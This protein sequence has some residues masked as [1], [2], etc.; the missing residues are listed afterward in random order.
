MSLLEQLP[1]EMQANEAFKDMPD[2][3][4]LA[5]K[6]LELHGKSTTGDISLLSE[7]TR[8]DP[9]LASFKNINDL[10]KSYTETK[11]LVGTIKKAP[12]TADGYKFSAVE[13]LDPEFKSASD[14]QKALA[15]IFH[16]AGIDNDKADLVQKEVLATLNG[17]MLKSREARKATAL[18]NE[19][20]LREEW[21]GDYE[22]NFSQVQ[23]V[24]MRVGGEEAI[25]AVGDLGGA[26][27]SNVTALKIVHKLISKLSED[28][29]TSLGA[30]PQSTPD[31]DAAGKRIAEMIKDREIGKALTNERHPDHA[32]YTK[33]WNEMNALAYAEK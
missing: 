3:A 32:K 19:T 11:K 21:G 28:S 29:I 2:T 9:S 8:K 4:T 16:K 15:G 20:K 13:G 5:T 18:A 23:N 25:K 7:E 10:A 30:A 14:T 31:K 33:E 24:L 1:Q 12:E 6:Y 26:L 17:G 22:K 27:K